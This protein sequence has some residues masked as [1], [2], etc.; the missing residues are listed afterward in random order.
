[1]KN[2]NYMKKLLSDLYEAD[3]VFAQ[4]LQ[5]SIK[6]ADPMPRIKQAANQLLQE[7]TSTVENIEMQLDQISQTNR[8][9]MRA[10]SYQ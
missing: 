4:I 7:A 3:K 2:Q 9:L 8:G 1:M 6:K 5:K 10:K